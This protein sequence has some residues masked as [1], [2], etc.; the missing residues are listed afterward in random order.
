M[1]DGGEGGGLAPLLRHYPL[2]IR[3]SNLAVAFSP[4]SG[5]SHAVLWAFLHEG[6]YREANAFD[7]WPHKFR[8]HVYHR[9]PE[10][11]QP[12]RR[13]LA[14]GG[15]GMTLLRITRTP[16]NRL[17]S[18]FRHVC[19]YPILY[20]PVKRILGFDVRDRGLSL[21]D[22]D[23]VLARMRLVVPTAADPHVRA[24]YHPLWDLPFDRVITLNLDELPLEPGL[25]AVERD[26]GLP[27]T[28]FAALPEFARL[29]ETHYATPGGFDGSEPIETFRFKPEHTQDFPRSALLASPRL[30]AMAERHHAVDVGRIASGDTAG[31]LFQPAPA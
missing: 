3:R 28:D 7:P 17:V 16:A 9:R 4:K 20:K 11:R 10:F 25:N 1:A 8:L 15:A 6:L 26:L 23:R 14:T 30:H 2:F 13:L 18:I 29:R 27:P 21:A 31:K 5:C 12:V 19:R 24:Q 22:L